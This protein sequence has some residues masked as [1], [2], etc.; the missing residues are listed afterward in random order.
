MTRVAVVARIRQAMQRDRP[1]S[2]N[3]ALLQV[4]EALRVHAEPRNVLISLH[5]GEGACSLSETDV[6]TVA[7]VVNELATNAIKHAFAEARRG[8]VWISISPQTARGVTVVV[9]DDGSAFPDVIG[10]GLGMGLVKRLMASIGGLFIPPAPG[11]KLFEL[12]VPLAAS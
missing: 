11:S 5:A 6:A 10:S 12:R 7:L 8:H 2:L 9:D 1:P 3:V 4:C